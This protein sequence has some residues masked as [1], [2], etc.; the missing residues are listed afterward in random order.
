MFMFLI[1]LWQMFGYVSLFTTET[2]FLTR[3]WQGKSFAGNFVIPAVIWIFLSLSEPAKEGDGLGRIKYGEVR[4][5]SDIYG[6]TEEKQQ[7]T[8][9]WMLLAC[10]NFAAGASSSLAIL[11]S[12]LMTA[13]FGFLFA[14]REKSFAVLVKAGLACIPG[15]IYVLLYVALTHGLL[16]L[17]V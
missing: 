12:C 15:G 9:L 6:S 14:F 11:L 16:V 8:G 10:L 3:T 1:A 2:F 13:G 17:P 7:N 4:R 5:A